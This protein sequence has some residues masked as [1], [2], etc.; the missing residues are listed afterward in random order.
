MIYL[1][2]QLRHGGWF[3]EPW[4]ARVFGMLEERRIPAI[5]SDVAGRRDVLHT[6][7]TTPVAFVRFA[8]NDLHATDLPRL[9]AWVERLADWTRAGVSSVF[10]FLHQPTEPYIVELAAHFIPELERRLGVGLRAP[11]EVE[12]LPKQ[13]ELFGGA[14][15]APPRFGS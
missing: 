8:G 15:G 5:L 14:A 9:E 10:F 7:L 6:R 1:L 3:R 2:Y 4:R 11:R 13:G 12:P